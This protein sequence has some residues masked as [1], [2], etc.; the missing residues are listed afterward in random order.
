MA[1]KMT[2]VWKFA[3]CGPLDDIDDDNESEEEWN[4]LTLIN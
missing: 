1:S 2:R 3:K 4:S